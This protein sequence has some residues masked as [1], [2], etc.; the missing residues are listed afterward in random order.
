[1]ALA[2][3]LVER[4]ILC[5]M[6]RRAGDR[7][8]A[9]DHLGVARRPFQGLH[10]AHGAADHG[11]QLL[12][13]QMFDN[14]LLGGDHVR[15]RDQR[16]A[17]AERFTGCRINILRSGRAHATGQ[18]V[19]ADDEV[20]VGID[21]PA[22]ADNPFP[23]ARPAGD[24]MIFGDILVARQGVADED[25]IRVIGVQ[26]PVSLV[27][28]RERPEELA[29]GEPHRFAGAEHKPMAR[30]VGDRR[31]DCDARAG[32]VCAVMWVRRHVL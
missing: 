15:D 29:R 32:A 7:D 2:S 17:Q 27:G 6:A 25:R 21:G 11:K 16:K 12:D 10:R 8:R 19:Y 22:G 3:D 28:D 9:E 24:R 1:M 18:D 5:R 4:D 30:Q 13:S 26:R 23:P 31:F 20:I 14:Q